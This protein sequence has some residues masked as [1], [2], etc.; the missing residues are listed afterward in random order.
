MKTSYLDHFLY[1]KGFHKETFQR[2]K[3]FIDHTDHACISAQL[4][5]RCVF[6]NTW[7]FKASTLADTQSK[8][9]Q[10][11]ANTLC[12]CENIDYIHGSEKK[13]LVLELKACTLTLIMPQNPHYSLRSLFL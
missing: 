3:K 5:T 12:E 2:K 8:I 11:T 7:I 6:I 4:T 10:A 1:A 9:P 13:S